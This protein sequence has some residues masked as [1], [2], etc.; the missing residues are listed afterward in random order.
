MTAEL[1]LIVDSARE[2]RANA[3]A[4]EA[5]L[6]QAHAIEVLRN[7]PSLREAV[8]TW[9]AST[10]LAGNWSRTNCTTPLAWN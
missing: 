5:L 8:E 2:K 7:A 10:R 9:H 4:A 6:P 1:K 3:F